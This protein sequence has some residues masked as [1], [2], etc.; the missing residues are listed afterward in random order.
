[1]KNWIKVLLALA[2]CLVVVYVMF[3]VV[4]IVYLPKRIAFEEARLPGI[5]SAIAEM[6]NDQLLLSKRINAILDQTNQENSKKVDIVYKMLSDSDINRIAL[7]YL[8]WDFAMHKS[9]FAGEVKHVRELMRQQKSNSEKE[10]EEK[11]SIRRKIRELEFRKRFLYEE[12]GGHS[13]RVAFGQK[14]SDIE[15]QIHSL[16]ACELSSNHK[17]AN[18]KDGYAD[19]QS[20]QEKRLFGIARDYEQKTIVVLERVIAQRKTLFQAD[21]RRIVLLRHRYDAL[22]MWPFPALRRALYELD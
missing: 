14:L 11:D 10:S 15:T 18:T 2:S 21:E 1:M 16:K 5:K 20:Q 8:G 22:D 3:A 19:V 17:S 4:M 7:N 6:V 12:I 9:S 13:S